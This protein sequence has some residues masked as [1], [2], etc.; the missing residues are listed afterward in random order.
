MLV[1]I[2]GQLVTGGEGSCSQS[3]R[4]QLARS[5]PPLP[6]CWWLGRSE[7]EAQR[8]TG[9]EAGGTGQRQVASRPSC[10]VV[11]SRLAGRLDTGWKAR[12]SSR[13][14]GCHGGCNL[15]ALLRIRFETADTGDPTILEP[16][17]THGDRAVNIGVVVYVC[18]LFVCRSTTTENKAAWPC[19]M[20][21]SRSLQGSHSISKCE[22]W[23]SAN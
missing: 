4:L 3:A 13:G 11:P 19:H 14:W 6:G 12:L 20:A 18:V 5:W 8:R 1:P 9:P 23:G 21:C 22:L 16:Q 2:A 10:Q 15:G 7:P 17:E